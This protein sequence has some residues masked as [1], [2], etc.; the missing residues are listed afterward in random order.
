MLIMSFKRLYWPR[1]E[2]YGSFIWI[3]ILFILW[4]MYNTTK[5]LLLRGSFLLNVVYFDYWELECPSETVLH[6]MLQWTAVWGRWNSHVKVA[7]VE[8]PTDKWLLLRVDLYLQLNEISSPQCFLSRS[9][10]I[11]SPYFWL[12]EGSIWRLGAQFLSHWTEHHALGLSI[13]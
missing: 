12:S 1:H 6:P 4:K 9:N 13:D 3:L 11:K 5:S 2:W 8:C 7:F 10:P